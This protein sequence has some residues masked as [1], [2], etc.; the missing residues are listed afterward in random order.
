M[1]LTDSEIITR[2]KIKPKDK[3]LDVGG[4]MRQHTLIKVNTLVDFIRPEAVPYWPSKLSADNFVKVDITKEK[5]PFKSRQF[6][7][8]L[9]THTLE[10]LPNP[11]LIMDEMTRVAKRG[12]IVTPSMGVDME[13]GPVDYTDWLTG[14]RRVPGQAHHKWFFIK[15]GNLLK[16]VPKNYPILYTSEFYVTH[17]SGEKEVIYEW[18]GK[19][20]YS[21]F[22]GVN[23]HKLIEVY[24]DYISLN[25]KYI[26]KENVL[27]F[28]DSPLN[29]IKA[30]LKV[31]L[32]KGEGYSNRRITK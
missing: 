9:C 27:F 11:F 5:L 1:L 6:D 25:S 4:S 17:W 32:H 15:N 2:L 23:I 7:V 18:A 10:D 22:N 29:F 20:N 3:I 16:V 12:L 21:E 26:K 28:V 8:C 30:F 31:L 19:I 14:A 13:F 24:E